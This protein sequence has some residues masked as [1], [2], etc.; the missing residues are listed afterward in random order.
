MSEEK[1]DE[2][3]DKEKIDRAAWHEE[4]RFLKR[5][6]WA[7]ATA[8]GCCFLAAIRNIHLT[9]L[10]RFL[11]FLFIAIGVYAGWL[12]LDDLTR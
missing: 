5:Q 12:V 9:A 7:V 10:D 3:T 2:L 8:A 6:Q 4:V 1:R 11:A